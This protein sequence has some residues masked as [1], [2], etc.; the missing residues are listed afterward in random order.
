[1]TIKKGDF[2]E[3]E[4]K[5]MIKDSNIVFDT[6]DEKTAKYHNIFTERMKYG[7]LIACIGETQLL[8]GLDKFIEGKEIGEF[9]VNIL[10][11]D[12]FGKKSAKLLRLIPLKV[13]HQQNINPFPGLDVNIDGMNGIVRSVSGGRIIVDFNHPLSGRE[14]LY[15]VK[16]NRIV[17]DTK[18]KLLS[19]LKL[20]LNLTDTEVTISDD[21]AI[22]HSEL[23][24]EIADMIKE[25]I[26]KLIPEIK[27]VEFQKTEKVEK[28]KV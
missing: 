2:I 23:P 9:K 7:P 18:E 19:L 20:E 1:M 6:T 5:G 10:P 13:F 22:I 12:G 25:R 11:E 3:L 17:T 21:K 28:E 27:S 26:T 16:I 8:K 14:L 4:Y 24:K 15:E